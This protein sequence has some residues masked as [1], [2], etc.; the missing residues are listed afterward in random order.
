M[1]R[2]IAIFARAIFILLMS[3]VFLTRFSC[4]RP[5]AGIDRTFIERT[6]NYDRVVI[7]HLE[8]Q[9]D[10]DVP[11]AIEQKGKLIVKTYETQTIRYTKGKI[12]GT[13]V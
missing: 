1:R 10:E 8:A 11:M 2:L 13:K 9:E 3:C 7:Y 5:T 4:L 6:K 12:G